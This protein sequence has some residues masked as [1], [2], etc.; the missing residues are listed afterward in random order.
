VENVL[1]KVENKVWFF[2]SE[3]LYLAQKKGYSIKE[4]PV[5][6]REN[7]VSILKVIEMEIKNKKT[8]T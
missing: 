5:I 4:V 3:L 6:W 1:N 7:D 8:L 2:D